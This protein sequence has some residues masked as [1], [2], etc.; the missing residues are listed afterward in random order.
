MAL[1]SAAKLTYDLCFKGN[2][3]NEM[4]IEEHSEIISRLKFIGKIQEGEKINVKY[5]YVQPSSML[6]RLS[7]SFVHI[8]NRRNAFNFIVR[9]VSRSFDIIF[10]YLNS[11]KICDRELAREIIKDVKDSK[12]GIKC[13]KKTYKSDLMMCC[14]FELYSEIG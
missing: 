10:I 14:E 6:T 9:T 2:M 7:R 1:F 4:S 13:L 12:S 8:D 5:M 3:N 11:E